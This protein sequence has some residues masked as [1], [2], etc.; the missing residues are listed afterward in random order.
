[1]S[2]RDNKG[3]AKIKAK[4]LHSKGI[5]KKKRSKRSKSKESPA[6]PLAEPLPNTAAAAEAT[7]A[8]LRTLL[9]GEGAFGFAAALALAWCD[10]TNLVATTLAGESATYAEAGGDAEDNVE[11]IKAFGGSVA[12]KVDATQLQS[13]DTVMQRGGRNG[14]ERIIF[15]FP[16]ATSGAAFKPSAT[17]ENQALLRGL[18]KSVLSRGLLCKQPP[19]ELQLTLRNSE[20]RDWKLVEVAKLAG[21]RVRS[22]IPFEAPQGY[23]PPA[24]A[25]GAFTYTLF[26]PPPMLYMEHKKAAAVAALA[27]A[28]PD[29]RLGPTGQTYKEAWKQRHKKSKG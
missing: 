17:D 18:F 24:H 27:R 29:L 28:R 8:S 11:T 26:L 9:L 19:G 2:P 1:M 21:L 13:S 3:Q 14:Y 6:E 25:E 5:P 12:F 15:N 23:M 16:C 20:A 4:G 22:C 10:C 7:A